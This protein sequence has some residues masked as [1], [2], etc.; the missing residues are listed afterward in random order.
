M[1]YSLTKTDG[2]QLEDEQVSWDKL[3]A[4]IAEVMQNA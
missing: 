4:S 1:Y 2:E 3:A